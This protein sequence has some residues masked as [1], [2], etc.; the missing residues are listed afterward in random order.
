M[1]LRL[2][3]IALVTT[4]L[5][6]QVS[7][8]SAV[9]TPVQD[10]TETKRTSPIAKQL[11]TD[12]VWHS[13]VASD[14]DSTLDGATLGTMIVT[15]STAQY[16]GFDSSSNKLRVLAT[17]NSAWS[18]YE[19]VL[20]A[21]WSA[22]STLTLAET[23]RD[24]TT[25]PGSPKSL[26]LTATKT[27][28]PADLTRAGLVTFLQGSSL[29]GLS[30]TT[31]TGITLTSTAA[32]ITGWGFTAR[33]LDNGS[34]A[35]AG[36]LD[37]ITQGYTLPLTLSDGVTTKNLTTIVDLSQSLVAA[38]STTAVPFKFTNNQ[39]EVDF[40]TYPGTFVR[41]ASV[42]TGYLGAVNAFTGRAITSGGFYNNVVLADNDLIDI[43]GVTSGTVYSNLAAKAGTLVSASGYAVGSFGS[44]ALTN[45]YG[46]TYLGSTDLT[47]AV[48]SSDNA[49][50]V[51]TGTVGTGVTDTFKVAITGPIMKTGTQETLIL[52]SATTG[53]VVFLRTFD[54]TGIDESGVTGV[55]SSMKNA[56]V[57]NA[58]A[59]LFNGVVT[60]VA[61]KTFNQI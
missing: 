44:S 30:T 11:T 10:L 12:G 51:L 47:N 59:Q 50:L 8:L 19:L 3:K 17:S 40:N 37:P 13:T 52:T 45:T 32:A 2:S 7:M 15:P 36:T 33:F 21:S 27:G 43:V 22:T 48:W 60:T 29:T 4:A 57:A 26:V 23:K 25:G 5:M 55:S 16:W 54:S 14:L 20:S 31:G 24:G 34:T 53:R 58:L 35:F 56:I 1:T 46:F 28:T 38:N 49:N 9:L 42:N 18:L 39:L 61:H 6:T 41:T